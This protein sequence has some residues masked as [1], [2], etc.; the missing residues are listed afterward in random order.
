MSHQ[1]NQM[2]K[3]RYFFRN[4]RPCGTCYSLCEDQNSIPCVI[5]NRFFHRKCSKL[6]KKAFEKF[7]YGGKHSFICSNKCYSSA[8]PLQCSDD[9]DFYSAISGESLYPCVKCKRDCVEEMAC[10]QCSACSVW[11]HHICSNLTNEEFR[12]KKFFYCSSQCENVNISF[13]P[14]NH[15]CNTELLKNDIIMK[16]KPINGYETSN[17]SLKKCSP[18]EFPSSNFIKLD[19]F[20]DIK[21]SYLNPNDLS[22]EHLSNGN[23]SISVFHNNLRSMNKNMDSVSDIFL[24]CRNPPEIL[25]FSETRLNSKSNIPIIEGYHPFEGIHSPTAAGGVGAYISNKIDYSIRNDLSLNLKGCENIWFDI[26]GKQSFV[27]G[28]IYRHPKQ[29]Y[30]QFRNSLCKSLDVLNKERTDCVIVGDVHINFLKY[31]VATNVTNYANYLNSLG[32]RFFVDKPTRVTKNTATCIDHVYSNMHTENL[33]NFIVM[34]DVSDH[35]ST[36]TKIIDIDKSERVKDIF[37]RKSNLNQREWLEFNNELA[38][39][40]GKILMP[41]NMYVDA[42][43]IAKRI[44]DAYNSIINKFMPLKKLPIQQKRAIIKP[45]ITKGLKVSIKKKNNLFQISKKINDQKF[46][47]EYKSYRNLLTLLKNKSHDN[48]YKDK[49]NLYGQ[50]KIRV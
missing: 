33:D 25:A 22:E 4:Y 20:L 43:G 13:L 27:V 3:T 44:V 15:F 11:C 36:L 50:N 1:G 47:D 23:S 12:H 16:P 49:L 26:G 14:F 29:K 9:I 38:K 31:D 39:A 7:K 21:C 37:Y 10:I 45:W 18:K 34:S 48:Y 5:C 46:T 41:Q 40:L 32:C 28:V 35:F 2:K 6:S 24:N 19:H 30:N 42:N 17:S 8:L